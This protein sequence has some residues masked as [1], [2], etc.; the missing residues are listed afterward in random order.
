MGTAATTYL[1]TG[2]LFGLLKCYEQ[3][4]TRLTIFRDHPASPDLEWLVQQIKTCRT[5]WHAFAGLVPLPA[6]GLY[7]TSSSSPFRT[8]I[9]ADL[10]GRFSLAVPPRPTHPLSTQTVGALRAETIWHWSTEPGTAPGMQEAP[11]AQWWKQ[12]EP[13][14]SMCAREAGLFPGLSAV[15]RGHMWPVN[16]EE[17]RSTRAPASQA[18]CWAQLCT[19]G[20][21]AIGGARNTWCIIIGAARC[22]RHQVSL[23]G[24]LILLGTLLSTQKEGVNLWLSKKRWGRAGSWFT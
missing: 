24:C 5:V 7:L 2:D 20:I 1:I 10:P 18:S 4:W 16:L 8:L 14:A 15:K 3:L 13:L 11:S 19:V 9:N 21:S 22:Y 12:K 23:W 6:A 17:F